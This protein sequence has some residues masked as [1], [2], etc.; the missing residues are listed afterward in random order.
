MT[1][2]DQILSVAARPTR[3]SALS[4]QEKLV[5]ALRKHAAQ[6]PPRVWMFSGEPGTGKTTVAKILAVAYQ[7][8]HMKL[9]GDPCDACY[10]KTS[11]AIHEV[12]AAE[13]SGVE[14]IEKLIHIAYHKPMQ[15][16]KRVLI[17]DEAQS[18]SA[19]AW[20]ALLKP[21]E[22][23]PEHTVWIFCTSDLRKVPAA[24]QR[25]PVKY[26]LRSLNVTET[27][28]FLTR[29]AAAIGLTAPLA[30]LFEAA[31]TL[32]VGAPGVLLQALEKFAAG[33]SAADSIAGADA[34]TPEMFAMAKALTSGRWPAVAKYLRDATPDH[35]RLIRA[36]V[37]S[38]LKGSLI[39]TQRPPKEQKAAAQGLIDLAI[40]PFDDAAMLP[41]LVGV[42]YKIAERYKT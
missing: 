28:K 29:H 2:T 39:K 30:P 19:T 32:G 42:L 12:N 26:A 20:K 8:R 10:A 13:H 5:A 1:A 40:A 36:F 25:R 41:W 35:A 3:L 18:L 15:G 34:S 27:E 33:A 38:W 37:S 23:T 17:M 21:T 6:R 24:N 7:C 11:W 16:N 4:G 14:E 31:H 9:W 22:E